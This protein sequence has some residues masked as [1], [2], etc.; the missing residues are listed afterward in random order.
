MNSEQSNSLL[1]KGT[2]RVHLSTGEVWRIGSIG[3]N[4]RL[5]IVSESTSA[6]RVVWPDYWLGEHW[7]RPRSRAGC[8][9][10]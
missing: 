5:R 2:R 9:R 4:G 10:S 3:A 6:L 1:Q 7:G 8:R